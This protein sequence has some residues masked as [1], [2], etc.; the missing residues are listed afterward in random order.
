MEK[1]SEYQWGGL[2]F[3]LL[4]TGLSLPGAYAQQAST[5]YMNLWSAVGSAGGEGTSPAYQNVSVIG[6]AA[7]TEGV[8]D[9][10][11]NYAGVIGMGEID[12]DPYANAWAGYDLS[13]YGFEDWAAWDGLASQWF[14]GDHLTST[15]SEYLSNAYNVGLLIYSGGMGQ[16]LNAWEYEYDALGNITGLWVT[17]WTQSMDTKFLV[18]L[19]FDFDS[20]LWLLD[21]NNLFGYGGWAIAGIKARESAQN[22]ATPE[23]GT[24][25]LVGMGLFGVLWL[26]R[27]RLKKGNTAKLTHSRKPPV[28]NRLPL[29]YAQ[30]RSSSFA[31]LW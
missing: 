1:L 26:G 23:P 10:F 29:I 18:S 24:L 2:L 3:V 4:L 15:I 7:G 20:G 22:A 6:Q 25:F 27:N 8:S 31:Q 30:F 19:M 11:A 28:V 12:A 16:V 21:A 13:D 14:S 9:N 17:D 5:N